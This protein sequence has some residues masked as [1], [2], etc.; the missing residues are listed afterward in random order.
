MQKKIKPSGFLA[1]IFKKNGSKAL[2]DARSGFV[3]ILELSTEG[4]LSKELSEKTQ[5]SNIKYLNK[6]GGDGVLEAC[7]NIKAYIITVAKSLAKT[8]VDFY[9]KTLENLQPINKNLDEII[10]IITKK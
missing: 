5:K 3:K 4:I 6:E 9:Q 10:K 2:N 8:N 1:G 7:G